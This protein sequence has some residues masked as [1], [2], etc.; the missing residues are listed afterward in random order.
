MSPEA[1]TPTETDE[2]QEQEHDPSD[3]DALAGPCSRFVEREPRRFNIS[4][5]V[6]EAAP[7]LESFAPATVQLIHDADPVSAWIV[8]AQRDTGISTLSVRRA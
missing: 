1:N 5:L 4:A 2:E 3:E 8:D 6:W 7:P